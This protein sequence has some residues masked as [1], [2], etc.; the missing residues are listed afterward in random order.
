MKNEIDKT[1]NIEEVREFM[2]RYLDLSVDR[3]RSRLKAT[4]KKQVAIKRP[5]YEAKI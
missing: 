2:D 1:Y 5:L 3:L 4:W